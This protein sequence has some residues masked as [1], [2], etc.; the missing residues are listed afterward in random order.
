MTPGG[1]V[2]LF[3]SALA[4]IVAP[5]RWAPLPLLAGAC[6]MPLGQSIP[7]GPFHF[8]VIRLLIFVGVVRV[9]IRSEAG[10]IRFRAIDYVLLLWAAC[11]LCSSAFHKPIDDALVYRLGLAYNALGVY[12]LIRV[13]CTTIA[14]A[15]QLITTTA[16]VLVPVAIAMVA[17]RITGINAFAS[18]GGIREFALVRDGVIRAEGPFNH[19]ILAGTVGAVS[20]PLMVGIFARRRLAAITGLAASVAMIVTSGSSGPLLAA[21][22][23]IVGLLLWRYRLYMRYF[24]WLALLLYLALDVL[25]KAPAYFILARIDVVGGSTGWH[26]AELIHSSINHLSE[27]WLA[28]TDY[29]RNWMPTGVSWSE[30]HTDITNQYLEYG[31]VGGLPLM[32]LFIIAMI[33]GFQYIGQ[34]LRLSGQCDTFVV[35]A[36]GVCLMAHA[37]SCIS[38][39]YFD[40]SYMFLFMTLALATASTTQDTCDNLTPELV[41]A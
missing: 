22:V 39:S 26:R 12:F 41:V 33:C 18:F 40:Q 11:A 7:I 27:W 28:G 10:A 30:N 37:T 36:I 38:V 21:S 9:A 25:M 17:E 13:C 16:F 14:D 31:V 1:Y 24:R 8:T 5:R 15:V 6:Y 34:S 2:F 4:V 35:W 3:F 32:I 19:P 29:T 23:G 20:L